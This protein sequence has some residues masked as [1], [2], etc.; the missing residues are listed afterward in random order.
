ML[1]E[2]TSN[3]TTF[4]AAAKAFTREGRASGSQLSTPPP[5]L[6]IFDLKGAFLLAVACYEHYPAL[7]SVGNSETKYQRIN[8]RN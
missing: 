1:C 6:F 4:M 7:S 2:G 3:E 5:S 8:M